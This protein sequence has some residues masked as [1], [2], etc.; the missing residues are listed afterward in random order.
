[1]LMRFVSSTLDTISRVN[2]KQT[3]RAYLEDLL[4]SRAKR[5]G[6]PEKSGQVI[7]VLQNDT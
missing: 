1:M 6:L 3:E 4:S 5:S 2:H 7:P